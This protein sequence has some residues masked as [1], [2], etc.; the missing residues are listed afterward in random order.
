MTEIQRAIRSIYH[1]ATSAGDP[2][3]LTVTAADW[4]EIRA[5]ILAQIALW[6]A[7]QSASPHVITAAHAT[8]QQYDTT[9]GVT[10]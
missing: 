10:P 3:T 8:V 4:P 5:A 2:V 7:Q 1:Y 9:F 6:E